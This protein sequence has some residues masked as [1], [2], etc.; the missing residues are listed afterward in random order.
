MAE[1]KPISKK[2]RFEVF[3]RD[4]FT[5][6]YCGRHAPDVVLECDHIKPVADGGKNTLLNLVTSCIDCNRGKG[7]R[8]LS[9]TAE[10]DKQFNELAALN[11][12]REQMT[13][14]LK[15]RE[16]LALLENE[17]IDA[18]SDIFCEE[19]Y[20]FNDPA[21]AKVKMLIRR[22]GFNEV[23]V[24]SEIAYDKYMA[25]QGRSISY[26]LHKL[27]GICYNRANGIGGG[28]HGS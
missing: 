25:A 5:C 27:G 13:M 22:F 15:W 26:A 28:Q 20:C 8:K 3:K 9:D 18:I 17:Q 21:R 10:V 16:E 19:G 11:E 23:L 2:M 24:S 6:Q 12:R 1:R 14:M 7:K 4:S